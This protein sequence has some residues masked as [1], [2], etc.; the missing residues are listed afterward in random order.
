MLP[1]LSYWRR[2]YDVTAANSKTGVNPLIGPHHYPTLS[3][4]TVMD[5]ESRTGT[6]SSTKMGRVITNGTSDGRSRG[7]A[8]QSLASL[9]VRHYVSASLQ[10]SYSSGRRPQ[11]EVRP[12]CTST[13]NQFKRPVVLRERG[14]IR[15]T[16]LTRLRVTAEFYSSGCRPRVEVRPRCTSTIVIN[17]SKR[18]VVQRR[19]WT[20]RASSY[21]KTSQ[22]PPGPARTQ[23]VLL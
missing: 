10:D 3:L 18:P 1:R 22:H 5:Y 12:R 21:G 11:V 23:T 19:R 20:I 13:I 7:E 6:R 14:T 8:A 2:H 4:C 15:T 9:K 16:Q 17:Q